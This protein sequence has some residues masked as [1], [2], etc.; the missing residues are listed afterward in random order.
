MPGGWW[1]IA[2]TQQLTQSFLRVFLMAEVHACHAR[3]DRANRPDP[4]KKL[5]IRR[6]DAPTLWTTRSQERAGSPLRGRQLVI[7]ERY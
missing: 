2:R 4:R 1:V 3:K 7:P 6:F 5:W